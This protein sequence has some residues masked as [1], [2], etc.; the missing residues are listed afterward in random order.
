VLRCWYA[1][2]SN[3]AS[4]I[5]NNK[6]VIGFLDTL[7]EFRDLSLE[8]WNFRPIVQDNLARLHEQQRVYWKQ[9]GSIK[10]ATLGDENTKFFHANATVRHIRNNIRSWQDC[11]GTERFQHD[12]KANLL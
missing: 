8:D 7:E 10:W 6:M 9:R 3:L 1:N 2:I 4:N 11:D 5:K 12:D